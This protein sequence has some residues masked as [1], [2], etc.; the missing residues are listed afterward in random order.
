MRT[1]RHNEPH[2]GELEIQTRA[3]S[4]LIGQRIIGHIREVIGVGFQEFIQA[5]CMFFLATT[6]DEGRLDCTFRGGPPGFVRVVDDRTLMFPDYNGNGAFMSVGNLLTNPNVGML[7]IDFETQRRIRVNGTAEIID[8][9]DT[10]SAFPGAERVVKVTVDQ[11]FPNCSRY[12]PRMARVGPPPNN[13]P[14][15]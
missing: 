14:A 12:I 3:G 5:Q 10:V 6:D 11:A 13:W 7:F 15:P 2:P 1:R 4:R 9:P 8:D